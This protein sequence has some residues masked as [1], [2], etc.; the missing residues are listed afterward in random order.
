[1]PPARAPVLPTLPPWQVQAAAGQSVILMPGQMAFTTAAAQLRTLLGSCVSITLWH[2]D[3]RIGGMCH[4]LLP[5][6]ARRSGEALDGRFGDEA[7]HV[8][9]ERLTRLGT[10]PSEYVAHLY[11]GADTLPQGTTT[12]FN[13]GER[14]IE[15]G[16]K[17]IDRY[18]FQ[19]EGV[20]VGEDVP[21][22]VSID[23][24]TGVVDMKR[25]AGKAPPN[26]GVAVHR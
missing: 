21:R 2:P 4:Y 20:D 13:V 7:V 11:G 3:R 24:A 25:G 9:V 23:L 26:P 15:F 8:M 1:M 16:W 10:Q 14:N 6:R 22:T 17:L 12:K 18:G 19:L 5:Q